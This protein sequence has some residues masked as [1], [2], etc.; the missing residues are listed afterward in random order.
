M[1]DENSVYI[2]NIILW[3]IYDEGID[4][5]T[6]EYIISKCKIDNNYVVRMVCD[7]VLKEHE[8]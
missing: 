2:K 7:K 6:R 5:Q 4:D 3:H 8:C 1:I